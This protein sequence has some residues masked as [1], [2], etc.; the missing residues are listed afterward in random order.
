[1]RRGVEGKLELKEVGGEVFLLPTPRMELTEYPRRGFGRSEKPFEVEFKE[2]RLATT[3]RMMDA[4][5]EVDV[6][7]VT[8]EE[9]A[10]GRPPPPI[11]AGQRPEQKAATTE[12]DSDSEVP[13]EPPT[14]ENWKVT[15]R[16]PSAAE[17]VEPRA[18]RSR[19]PLAVLILIL[20]VAAAVAGAYFAGLP[21]FAGAS[22]GRGSD[23][24]GGPAKPGGGAG[25]RPPVGHD[26]RFERAFRERFRRLLGE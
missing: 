16:R 13:L 3:V 17:R 23:V 5:I 22:G 20:I 9:A 11:I 18:P 25:E 19:V 14:E 26:S 6:E 8:V 24:R 15:I 1:M 4:P 7:P 10:V 21:P 2:E 12:D